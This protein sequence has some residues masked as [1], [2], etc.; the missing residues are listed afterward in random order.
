MW[1]L[2]VTKKS[3]LIAPLVNTPHNKNLSEHKYSYELVNLTDTEVEFDVF[4]AERVIAYT[5]SEH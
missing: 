3:H 5:Y 1:L 4:V 2:S